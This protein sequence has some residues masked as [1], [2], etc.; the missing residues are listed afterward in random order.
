MK[1]NAE[2][3]ADVMDAIKWEPL[4][5]ATEIGVT[6][7]D[8]VVSL[9][10]EVDSYIEKME[11]ENTAK[12]VIGVKILIKK[13]EVKTPTKELKTDSEVASKILKALKRIRS[14]PKGQVIVNVV[15]GEVT[16]SGQLPWNYIS[17][18]TKNALR[19]ISGIKS[20]TNDIKIKSDSHDPIEQKDVKNALRRS[21]IN[22]YDINVKVSG[23]AVT[24]SGKTISLGQKEEAERITWKTPG[25]W[26][27]NNELELNF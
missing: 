19:Y 21:F 26:H 7:E 1:N 5:Y 10:G 6:A 27:V 9:T 16:L 15:N 8:G 18:D 3:Q 12:K 23:T 11:A 22:H 25:I 4:L 17:V 13:I 2:L 24:L 20:I 14:L